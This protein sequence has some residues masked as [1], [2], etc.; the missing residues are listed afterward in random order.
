MHCAVRSTYT[1]NQKFFEGG[2]FYSLNKSFE[3]DNFRASLED[4]EIAS[5]NSRNSDN[6]CAVM[7]VCTPE[8]VGLWRIV[9]VPPPCLDHTNQ[10]GSVAQ[11]NMD[12]LHL[13]SPS[14]I[15]SFKVD[16]RKAQKGSVHDVTYPVKASTLRRSPGSDVQQQSRNRTLANKVTKLNE[17][18]S[19]SS[20]QSS[21]PCSNSSSVIQG[22]SN[23]FKSSNIFVENPKVNIVE[24]NSRNNARKKGKQNRKISCDSVSTGP[25]ILSSDNGHGILTSGPSDNVDID[26][27]DGLI[28]CAT[29]LEDSFLD[30]RNDINHIEEDNNGIC[31]SSESQKTCTSY[32]DEVNLSEAEVS[33]SA[34]SFAGEHPLTDSKMMVQM[35]DQGSVTDGGIEEQHPL[36]ISCYDAIHSNG[37]SDMNDCR[38]RDSVSIGSNSD[39]STSA[40]FDT[41]P[42][43]RESNKS[44]FSESA[45]SRSRKG[46]F[47]PLNLLSSVVDF[48]DYSEGKR[49]VNQGLNH[50]DMQVA[51]PGKWNKKAKMVPG[52]SNAL[53][54]RGARNSRISTGKENSHCVWQKVQKNDAN[55]CNSESRKANAV[56]SQFLGTVK[57]SSSL[58]RNSDM[59]DVNIPSKSEDKKQLRDKAPRKLKRKIS[60]GS[61]HEYNSYSRRAMYSSKASS[62]ACSKIVSQQN[63]I[64]D[65]SAQL[66]NQMR[67]SS[68]PSSCSDIG[69]PEFELQSSKV[70]SLNSESSHSLQDCP[71]NLESTERVSG[72]V[73]ALKEHQDSPLAK[74]CYSLDKM[75]MLE[76]P[77]PICLPH[78]IFN[79][80][81]QTEKDESLAEHGKQDHISGSPVQ[82]WIPIGTK[83]SQSTF[84]A[85][86]GSLQLAH[87][88]G[89]GTEYWTLRKNIDKKSASNSQNLISS[90]NVG[91]MSMGL[92]SES[93]SLQEYKDTRGM[94]GMNAYP[95]KGNNNVA[96][97]CLISESKDQNFSTFETGINKILQAVDNAC[98][99]QAA[100]EAVQMANGGR[101]AEFEQFLHFSSPVI[102]CKSNLSSCKNCSEDQVVG[103]SLCR[104]ETPNV[105]LECL[106]QWY[107]KQGSYGLEIRAEDYEQSNRLGVD[108]F[109]FRAYFVPFLSAVQLFRN[110]KSHSSSNG[111]G[112]PT[113]GVFGT[114]ETGQK[115]QSSAN[116]DHLPI[117]S[118]LFPQPHTSGA[119]SLPPVKELGKSE[120]SSVSDKESLSVPSVENSND[121][122]LLFEY[123]ESEQ[124]RQRRPL[125]E[126]IQELVTGE[127]PSNCS[128]YGDR[129]ILNTIN[130]CDLHPA[131]WYS[132]AW[133]PIYRI[134]DGNF[135][136]AF[137]TYHSLGHMVHRSANVDSANGKACIVSPAL[138]LQSYN[139]QGECWFQLKHST[140]S[141]TAESPTVSSSVILKE[142]LRTLEETASVMSRAVVNKG[143]QV[144]VNRHS[145]YEFFLSRRRSGLP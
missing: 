135:R 104:H 106:W 71:K 61:K 76:V 129:T 119:S 88:D 60:P 79:E 81:A 127:G 13:V 143:N 121:L 128:V 126:K 115:L 87:A 140:S 118:M 50:S 145:D 137:L 27:G 37:F 14:S 82:K 107:E 3:K 9:A 125:F 12:G 98:R 59:T 6:R 141:R 116:I 138:G 28:S 68:A 97:D 105:S 10:L 35:E 1:D 108:R 57:E 54:P 17:F 69:S 73:S 70:E 42:Y 74:S 109:S 49:Y 96:A 45:D 130:L 111:H 103:A 101:I 29:S 85:S 20:S 114:C 112:F 120:W 78:L 32:I 4:S 18:S 52:S 92:D 55:K 15:N 91:M 2:K 16:R 134:P 90:L 62:N 122:E 66:N 80:V 133:Y 43:G 56:C 53:K 142:R 7:T 46:S 31:N 139:A 25:E 144:S 24:R 95:F 11:G 44:S 117:F 47:S 58:K 38:V 132:V 136:A 124:P 110:R 77:S 67:V 64:L 131:S 123:F 22:R 33:S 102:S 84:S 48:C 41:K 72:A 51:V 94:M 19:S 36:R 26:H 23:S 83:D 21:I 65:V 63:E 86:C 113:S 100:S 99:M 40:S 8:S 5:L 30:G 34:P 39:N 75:N 89:K 93:K